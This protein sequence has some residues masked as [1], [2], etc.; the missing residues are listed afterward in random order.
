MDRVK[1]IFTVVHS[2]LAMGNMGYLNGFQDV[3][4]AGE[5]GRVRYGDDVAMVAII[6]VMALFAND[7]Q[8]LLTL[9]THI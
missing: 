5:G 7:A 8:L 6:L 9:A 3:A 2:S 1:H 4:V